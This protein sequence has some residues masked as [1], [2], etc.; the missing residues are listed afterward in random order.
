LAD[1]RPKV[2][3]DLIE[4][5]RGLS[6]EEIWAALKTRSSATSMPTASRFCH[7]AQTL[8]GRAFYRP[9]SCRNAPT[10]QRGRGQ[11]ERARENA[12]RVANTSIHKPVHRR[13]AL[14]D[15][16]KQIVADD[17]TVNLC[18]NRF[19][20]QHVHPSAACQLAVWLLAAAEFRAFRPLATATLSRSERSGMN[21]DR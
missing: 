14:Y 7:P 10:G 2:P 1:G 19:D 20:Y 18:R 16:I 11:G 12:S 8:V 21:W 5:A 15:V 17:G 9:V 3:D 13:G 6:A 4:R